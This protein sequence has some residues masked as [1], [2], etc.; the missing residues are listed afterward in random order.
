MVLVIVH[1]YRL[2][3]QLLRGSLQCSEQCFILIKKRKELRLKRQQLLGGFMP[4]IISHGPVMCRTT[5]RRPPSINPPSL[6]ERSLKSMEEN[7]TSNLT[8]GLGEESN[9]DC[10]SLLFSISMIIRQCP[11]SFAIKKNEKL[12]SG[13]GGKGL[14]PQYLGGHFIPDHGFKASLDL[15]LV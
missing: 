10:N 6:H 11:W 14:Q 3:Q 1:L 9:K 4:Q 15:M 13:H 2:T 8:K 7:K 5:S 12:E